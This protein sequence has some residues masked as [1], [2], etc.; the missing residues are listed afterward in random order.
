M[1][2][3]YRR[4]PKFDY[5]APKTMD[6]ALSLLSQYKGKAKVI[7]GG[8]DLV[9]QMRAKTIKPEYVVDITGIPGLDYT[10]YDEK[11]GLRIGALTTI[12]ALE[13]ST[14]LHQNYPVISPGS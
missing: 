10:N 2:T 6:E 7:A 5:L 3:F 11:Q 1:V 4:L 14:M 12:R 8:T 9:V 13:T